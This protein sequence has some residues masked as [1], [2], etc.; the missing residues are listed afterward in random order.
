[1]FSDPKILNSTL[2]HK[3]QNDKKK[4]DLWAFKS[5]KNERHLLL[6]HQIFKY[7]VYNIC[8]LKNNWFCFNKN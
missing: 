4:Q 6:Y 8:N 5:L 3:N 2:H 1:M 7:S